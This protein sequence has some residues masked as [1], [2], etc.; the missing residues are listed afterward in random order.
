MSQAVEL[1]RSQWSMGIPVV[2][3]NCNNY[4]DEEL[5]NPKRFTEEV[6]DKRA[7][8][9]NCRTHEIIENELISTFWRGFECE[10]ARSQHPVTKE[11][12]ILKLKDW[13][14]TEDFAKILPKHFDNLMKA[15]PF[16]EYT[17]RDG[18]FNLTSRLPDF[19]V[20]PDLGPKM[21]NAYGS[22]NYPNEAT[23]NLHLDVSD[24]A[25]LMLYVGILDNCSGK[26]YHEIVMKALFNEGVCR[27]QIRRARNEIPGALWHIY[28]A[29][30]TD[31]IR[32][33]LKKVV[34][35]KGE[36]LEHNHDPIHDQSSYLDF[37]L[38][39]RLKE[40]CNIEGYCLVQF[41]G[42]AIFIPGG[43]PHQVRNLHSCI[44]AAE[45]FVSPEHLHHSFRLTNEFRQLSD[46]HSNH[47]DKLQ[48]KNITYQ[49]IK[50]AVAVLK[51]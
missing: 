13:P 7:T 37:H 44:K 33:F 9:V 23:T 16:P 50:D 35:E 5:W 8:L 28:E 6:G 38:R 12:L 19:F 42:D 15:L 30:D 26:E 39:K 21:Y 43:A 17:H 2:A 47:E 18:V 3:S 40:E 14:P 36:K 48:I 20:R 41:L 29:K 27:D 51:Q 4:T 49:A 11:P 1:F 32:E 46:T 45:D 31:K 10:S 34:Q 24:A 25:N 22:A